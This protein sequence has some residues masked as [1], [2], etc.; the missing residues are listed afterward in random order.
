[1]E[2]K[3]HFFLLLTEQNL[4]QSMNWPVT[5]PLEHRNT[6]HLIAVLG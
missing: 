6:H 2:I 5:F 3:K 4:T 1:M